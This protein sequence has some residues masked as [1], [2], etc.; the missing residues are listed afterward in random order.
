[1]RNCSIGEKVNRRLQ[2]TQGLKGGGRGE[3]ERTTFAR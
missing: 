1:M 3:E 2:R